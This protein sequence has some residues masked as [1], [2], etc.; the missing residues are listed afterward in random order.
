MLVIICICRHLCDHF[1]SS[2]RFGFGLWP[3]TVFVPFAIL[4]PFFLFFS[5]LSF[6]Y[7]NIAS[8]FVHLKASSMFF[9]LHS[10]VGGWLLFFRVHSILRPFFIIVFIYGVFFLISFSF[11]IKIINTCFHVYFFFFF[12]L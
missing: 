4:F 6:S 3:H 12:S 2:M 8:T 1:A 10:G 5:F 11:W 7:L 9:G